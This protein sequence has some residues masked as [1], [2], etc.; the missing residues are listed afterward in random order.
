MEADFKNYISSRRGLEDLC[1]TYGR[2]D[3]T[4]EEALNDFP[5]RIFWSGGHMIVCT[6]DD[7]LE[8]CREMMYGY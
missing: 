6:D 7:M 3:K 1:E 8:T 5:S 2:T 4:E